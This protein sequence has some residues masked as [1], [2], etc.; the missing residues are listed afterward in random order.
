MEATPTSNDDAQPPVLSSP[1]PS[2]SATAPASLL[3]SLLA[4]VGLANDDTAGNTKNHLHHV[5]DKHTNT[6]H[7]TTAK[8]TDDDNTAAGFAAFPAADN[9]DKQTNASHRTMARDDDD[10]PPGFAAPGTATDVFRPE[11][12]PL[13]LREKMKRVE[14]MKSL[15][16]DSPQR[17]RWRKNPTANASSSRQT[18]TTSIPFSLHPR[19]PPT[20][21]PNTPQTAGKDDA[22]DDNN[23]LN[24]RAVNKG[25]S[26]ASLTSAARR[27]PSSPPPTT[28]AATTAKRPWWQGLQLRFPSLLS[29]DKATTD[30]LQVGCF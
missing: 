8:D 10:T 21:P 27:R 20:A 17:L 1:S 16:Y 3:S 7:L 2:F 26:R 30:T 14:D 6:S 23:N 4:R 25:G 24:T 13:T 11:G 18:K 12:S 29:V 19:S 15:N 22:A 28:P 9:D 5:A